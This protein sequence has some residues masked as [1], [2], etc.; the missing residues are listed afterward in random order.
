M[1]RGAWNEN[2]AVINGCS[3]PI[4]LLA[5]DYIEQGSDRHN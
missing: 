3:I 5:L 1:I 2:G 4:L